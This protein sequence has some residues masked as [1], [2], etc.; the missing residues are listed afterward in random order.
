MTEQPPHDAGNITDGRPI[1]K[2]PVIGSNTTTKG[3]IGDGIIG[4]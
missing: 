3:V 1:P 2:D 4:E